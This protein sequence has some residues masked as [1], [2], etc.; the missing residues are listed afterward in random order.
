MK[1]KIPNEIKIGAHTYKVFLKDNL[2]IDQDK[3]GV[4][5]HRAQTIELESAMP[6]SM[7]LAVLLHEVVH[8]IDEVYS[9]HTDED[10]T[11]RI[12]Q[13]LTGLLYN[14]NLRFD[15]SDIPEG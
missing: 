13:G 1:V 2:K 4:V 6:E 11:D 10:T 3:R 12:S 8:I 15:W 9:C 7:M 5:D 14:L